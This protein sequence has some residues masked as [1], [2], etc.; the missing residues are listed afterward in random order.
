MDAC[1][2]QTRTHWREPPG[3]IRDSFLE[4]VTTVAGQPFT[5][6]Q[7]MTFQLRADTLFDRGRG[8][9]TIIDRENLIDRWIQALKGYDEA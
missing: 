7:R 8:A 1:R 4:H 3:A 2:D 9:E 6:R 5:R